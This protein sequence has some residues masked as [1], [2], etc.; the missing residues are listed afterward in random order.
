[1]G[2]QAA[3]VVGLQA[4]DARLRGGVLDQGVE[5]DGVI[6]ELPADLELFL[7]GRLPREWRRG[8]AGTV[9]QV[10]ELRR[11]PRARPGAARRWRFGQEGT[12]DADENGRARAMAMKKT[13]SGALMASEA[14]MAAV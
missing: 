5:R 2:E 9:E 4:E 11:V 10:G 6:D 7:D 1:M 12:G 13:W 3:R 14:T 8:V